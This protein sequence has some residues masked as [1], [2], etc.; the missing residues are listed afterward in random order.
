MVVLFSLAKSA[1]LYPVSVKTHIAV[2]NRKMSGPCE[3]FLSLALPDLAAALYGKLSEC[4]W[5][6]SSNGFGCGKR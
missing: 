1:R 6:G 5:G 4:R 2:E 3:R